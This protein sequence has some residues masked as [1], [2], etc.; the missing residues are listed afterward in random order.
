MGGNFWFLGYIGCSLSKYHL[1]YSQYNMGPPSPLK[2]EISIGSW[3]PWM[4]HSSPKF[5]LMNL[6]FKPN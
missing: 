4:T 2:I 6:L 1:H 5:W 3:F